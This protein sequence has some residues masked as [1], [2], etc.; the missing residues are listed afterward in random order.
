MK[1]VIFVETKEGIEFKCDT[2]WSKSSKPRHAKVYSDNPN[3]L[4]GWLQ[5]ILP[6]NIYKDR[7]EYVN[8]KY[9]GA[10]LGYF[11]PDD[12]LFEGPYNLKDDLTIDQLGKP[13]YLWSIEMNEV[14]DW[15]IK[16]DNISNEKGRESV[17]FDS[18]SLGR[19]VDYKQTHRN[20]II[21]EVLKEKESE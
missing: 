15:I 8:D 7:I 21:S 11:T 5:S 2:F 20:D 16:R 14:S 18:S 3:E 10:K 19:F 9:Q 6:S 4:K 13:K 12:N 1:A 17:D